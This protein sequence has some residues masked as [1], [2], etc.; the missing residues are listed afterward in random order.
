MQEVLAD[1]DFKIALFYYQNKQDY[2]AS[3]ARLVELTDRYPLYSQ[4][5]QALW[6]LGDIYDRARQLSKGED[7]KNHWAD[8]AAKCYSRIL[9]QYPLSH[10]RFGS[11]RAAQ[12]D[13][14]PD[15]EAGSGCAGA[16]TAADRV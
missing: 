13:E 9:T 14:P 7:D 3:A 12:G 15:P 10:S 4:N 8:L 5:D 6:M 11:G 1:G 16:R 2:R